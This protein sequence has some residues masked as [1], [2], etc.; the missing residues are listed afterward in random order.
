FPLAWPQGYDRTT[1]YKRRRSQFRT[2][3]GAAR[4]GLIAELTRMGASYPVIS[5]NQ[6]LKRDGMPSAARAY[7]MDPGVAVYF[8][9][10]GKQRVLACDKWEKIEE[11]L[12]AVELAVQAM[13]GLDRWGVSQILD[14]VF[15][16]F[17]ALPPP[18][19]KKQTWWEVLGF[20]GSSVS[21]AQAETNY[22]TLIRSAH[23]DAGG[24]HE[25]A[26]KLNAAIAEARCVKG[27]S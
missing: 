26:Q 2:T 25:A 1:S 4:D 15:E 12:H 21:L 22:R 3:F 13:R 24:S 14:R 18:A 7:I 23:P 10:K 27:P 17:T 16:G 19:P 11:N 20:A 9:W 5:T 6:P 8:L